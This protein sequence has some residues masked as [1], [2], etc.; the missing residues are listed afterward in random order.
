MPFDCVFPESFPVVVCTLLSLLAV[1]LI[2]LA[3]IGKQYA[4]T[5]G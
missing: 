2:R 1:L 5:Q 3:R 4:V